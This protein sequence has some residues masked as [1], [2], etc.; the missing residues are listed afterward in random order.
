MTWQDDIKE[1]LSSQGVPWEE[2]AD[3]MEVAS[4][5]DVVYQTR[6]QRERFGDRINLYNEA[7]GKYIVD[8]KVMSVLPEHG[9]VLH[10]LPRLDE[11]RRFCFL[12]CKCLVR[13]T[14]I[15]LEGPEVCLYEMHGKSVQPSVGPV[16]RCMY[17]YQ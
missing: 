17:G 8:P 4:K 7:R 15:A 14:S 9:V 6:I 2:S 16:I 1:Y 12:L 11:V 10:P 3:L 13:W 5:C